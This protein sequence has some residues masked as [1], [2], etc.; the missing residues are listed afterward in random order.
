MPGKRI[1][2]TNDLADTIE[3]LRPVLPSRDFGTSKQYYSDLG[4]QVR[5]LTDR[6]AKI[7]YGAC[8]FLL[9]DYY[10]E[11][12]AK[13]CVMHL[14][15]TNVDCWWKHLCALDLP[16]R[17]GVSTMAPQLE[18]WGRVVGLTDPSGVLW[19]IIEPPLHSESEANRGS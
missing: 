3:A 12:W 10:V 2:V 5:M 16:S 11:Q 17:Y 9:Q 7:R 19:R 14:L 6:L 13:N 8:S 4:F 18:A 1:C 15:V